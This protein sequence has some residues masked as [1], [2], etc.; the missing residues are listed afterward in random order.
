MSDRGTGND[1]AYGMSNF[2][3]PVLT[4]TSF[5]DY[6]YSNTGVNDTAKKSYLVIATSEGLIFGLNDGS[7]Y[8]VGQTNL[9]FKK[10]DTASIGAAPASMKS[11]AWGN[12]IFV[13]TYA[14][15]TNKFLY[16]T[17]PTATVW[18]IGTLPSSDTWD[19][20]RHNGEFFLVIAKA[21]AIAY[22]SRDAVKWHAI[23][24]AYPNFGSI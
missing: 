10:V 14:G 13:S 6:A 17:E 19:F 11:V 2:K 1:G 22:L 20:V 23:N 18:K 12:N 16:S 3:L 4:S 21:S 5:N 8:A 15:S 9:T 24:G 7:L